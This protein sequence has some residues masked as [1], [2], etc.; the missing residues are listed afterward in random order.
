MKTVT[1]NYDVYTFDELSNDIKEKVINYFRNND[2]FCWNDLDNEFLE[3]SFKSQIKEKGYEVEYIGFSLGY[4][5]S[6][7]VGFKGSV[8]ISRMANRMLEEGYL[9]KKEYNRLM[10]IYNYHCFFINISYDNYNYNK[11]DDYLCFHSFI[12][13]E[14]LLEVVAEKFTDFIREDVDDI[15]YTLKKQ[16]YRAIDYNY[17]DEYIIE[18][19]EAN[20]YEFLSNGKIFRY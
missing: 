1:R 9:S 10:Y 14:G 12:K 2:Y 19:I 15:C 16:G 11:I 18:T 13:N 8:D 17:S 6:D 20:E 5:Q 4:T 3:D 7:Y